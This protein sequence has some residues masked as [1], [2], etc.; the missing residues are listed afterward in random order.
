[1]TNFIIQE[2]IEFIEK[3]LRMIKDILKKRAISTLK[4]YLLF[5]AEKKAEEIIESAISMNQ[6]MLK[7]YHKH[8]SKSYYES[9][10]DLR[11]LKIFSDDELTKLANTA[12]FRNRLAHDYLE[13]H[14]EITLKSIENLLRI[15]PIYL[16]RIKKYLDK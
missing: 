9:F 15:Y 3:T 11:K 1:M 10:L 4:D 2:K 6:E 14:P 5:A 16:K 13:L 12:G 7:K 8:L